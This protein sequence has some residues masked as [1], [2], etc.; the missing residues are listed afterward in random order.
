MVETQ[1]AGNKEIWGRSHDILNMGMR[2]GCEVIMGGRRARERADAMRLGI[3]VHIR[4]A[5]E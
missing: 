5:V 4:G 1:D 3:L 2:G